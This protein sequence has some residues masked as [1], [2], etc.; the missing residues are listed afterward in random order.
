MAM[1]KTMDNPDKPVAVLVTT[2]HRGVFFG[3]AK[4]PF[5]QTTIT[6]RDAQ[7]CVYW[8]GDLHG[9]LG[10]AS[11]G[12]TRS[13]RVGPPVPEITLQG[14]TAV[15]A[16]TEEAEREWKREYWQA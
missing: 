10:L 13:C 4:P 16:V 6:L 15:V 8:S 9:V 3:Y 5:D 11:R 14:I 1:S 12:P 2:Q 7:M